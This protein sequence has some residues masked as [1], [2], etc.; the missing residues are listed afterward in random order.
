MELQ[1][2]DV[3]HQIL[4]EVLNLNEQAVPAV[5]SLE[6]ETIA[7]FAQTA[8]YFRVAE[9]AD[10]LAGFL[11]A[12]AP[13]TDYPSHYFAWFC[14]HYTKFFYIDRVVVADW[15]RRRG[16]G[17]ALYEDIEQYAG[18][19]SYSLAAD[20]YSQPPNDISLAFHRRY[21]FEKVGSQLVEQDGKT[22]VKFLKQPDRF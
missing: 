3:D 10:H 12:I 17:W 4:S 15:A 6:M 8:T 13:D 16:V 19:S 5:N 2:R 21:G 1:I 9:I 22:V 14:Q 7:W 20:V 18:E 11:I